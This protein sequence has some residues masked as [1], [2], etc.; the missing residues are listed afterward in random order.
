MATQPPRWLSDLR[1]DLGAQVIRVS[2]RELDAYAGDAWHASAKPEAAALPRNRDEV[3]RILAF[4]NRRGIPLTTR[5]AGRGYVG[6]CV[7]VRGGVVLSTAR[8]SRLVS[9]SKVDSVAVAEPGLITAKLRKAVERKGLFYPPDPASLDES[10]IGGNIATNA[11]GPRCV[12]YGVTGHYVLGLHVALADGSVAEMGGRCHKNKTGFNLRDLFIGSEGM[13]G[14]IVL[15]TLRLIPL[16]LARAAAMAFFQTA[17]D[18]ARAVLEIQSRGILPSA[19]EIAD[20]FTLEAARRESSLPTKSGNAFLLVEVDGSPSTVASDLKAV[21]AALNACMPASLLRAGTA[22]EVEKLWSIRRKF[23]YNLKATGLIKLNEDVVV[24]RG[25]LVKLFALA[26]RMQRQMGISVACFGHAGDGNI[27][28]NL[29]M[30]K[31]QAESDEAIRALDI[32]FENVL[33]WGGALSGEHG[34]GLA[35]KRWWPQALSQ[36][37]RNIHLAIKKALDPK[38]IL[39]PGKFLD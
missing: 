12:K 6:G 4:C 10:S 26:E 15:A 39:N 28:V 9:I 11:G 3:S 13:L 5:G 1:N 23:S 34:I 19:M 35:K 36:E 22:A 37:T 21:C 2:P 7:P 30:E 8:M 38:G 14:V 16:P 27:H 25:S 17:H 29:M 31:K 20:R 33:R 32:L 18:A 24:P